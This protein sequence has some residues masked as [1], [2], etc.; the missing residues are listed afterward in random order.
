MSLARLPVTMI[1]A[2]LVLSAASLGQAQQTADWLT[3]EDFTRDRL[4][5]ERADGA[6][7]SF[8]VYLASTP[9]QQTQGMMGQRELPEDMGMLFLYYPARPVAMWMRN[10]L[11]P[12][13]MLFIRA[14]GTVANIIADAQ[15]QTLTRRSSEGPVTAVLELQGGLAKKL[16]LAPGDTVRHAHFGNAK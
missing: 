8:T 7:H 6:E 4:T 3:L 1:L 16:S 10:T 9:Q 5:I 2:A 14:D 15:P 12:L 13:D 11:I